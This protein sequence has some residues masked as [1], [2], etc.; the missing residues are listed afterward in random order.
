MCL[1][2]LNHHLSHNT[3]SKA[4]NKRVQHEH[5]QRVHTTITTTSTTITTLHLNHNHH[6]NHNTMSKASNKRVRYIPHHLFNQPPPTTNI[7]TTRHHH[8]RQNHNTNA[9]NMHLNH[10]EMDDGE[11]AGERIARSCSYSL[12]ITIIVDLLYILADPYIP[13]NPCKNHG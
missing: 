9:P 5:V 11:R 12:Y 13:A 10:K 4:S 2:H 1:Y 3:T 8:H 6:L 7:T